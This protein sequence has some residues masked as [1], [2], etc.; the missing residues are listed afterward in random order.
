MNILYDI[1]AFL[2]KGIMGL[3]IGKM[4]IV[5]L[6][7]T[8]ITIAGVTIF[9]HRS[10]AHRSLDL[11]AIPSHF[12]RF[13][14]W[15]TTGMVTKE[16]VAIHRKHHAKCETEDDPHSPQIRGIRKIL[17]EGAELYRIESKNQETLDK[18]GHGTP[19]DWIERNLYA[20]HSAKG[21]ILMLIL[22]V[23]LF[24]VFGLTIWAIQMAWIPL[25]AAGV[26][27]GLGHYIG[28]RNFDAP[29]AST[30]ISPWGILIGGEELHNNHHTYP[31]S[32]RLSNKWYEFDI[33]WMYI[34]ILAFFKLATIKKVAPVVKLSKANTETACTQS[35][36]MALI[37]HRYDAM[38]RYKRMLLA[39]YQ[40]EAKN[41]SVEVNNIKDIK[42][43]LLKDVKDLSSQEQ[44]F[45]TTILNQS[46]SLRVLYDMRQDLIRLWEKSHATSEQLLHSLQEWC[47]KAEASGM[48]VLEAFSVRVKSY[49]V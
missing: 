10:Q 7:F 4:F 42:N 33:G 45:L 28:Y 8:H 25:W 47:K 44:Q 19:D 40:N 37:H 2:E 34:K 35:T 21:I 30:N 1:I 36:L 39:T 14:L 38:E 17:L 24:G 43:L 48:P 22:N 32:A 13:W 15:L 49:A 26:I 16:W 29:D 23:S 11:H 31:T 41:F 9:L 6:I 18:F 27:N 20:K 46:K 3:S 12:F 5:S